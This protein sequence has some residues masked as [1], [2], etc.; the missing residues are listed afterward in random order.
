[1]D[2]VFELFFQL[3]QRHDYLVYLC[4]SIGRRR[5]NRNWIW[6][7]RS[8]A[9]AVDELMVRLAVSVSCGT[10][11]FTR[12]LCRDLR[13]VVRLGSVLSGLRYESKP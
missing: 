3:G 6:F 13:R 8:R 7:R 2:E 12:V 4:V 5:K 10:I 1:M 11:V 9:G